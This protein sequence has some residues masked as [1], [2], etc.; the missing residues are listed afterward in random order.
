M[1]MLNPTRASL[2]L[3][4]TFVCRLSPR[5]S[6][7]ACL[8]EEGGGVHIMEYNGMGK[9]DH[10][11]EWGRGPHN[12]EWGAEMIHSDYVHGVWSKNEWRV[13]RMY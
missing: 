6:N 12:M 1:S 4:V 10:I 5:R 3:M 11:M 7:V 9:R 2:R 8:G 13:G